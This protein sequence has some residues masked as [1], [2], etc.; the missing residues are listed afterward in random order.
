MRNAKLERTLSHRAAQASMRII[1]SAF[2]AFFRAWPLAWRISMKPAFTSL[3][4][5][6]CRGPSGLYG[7]SALVAEF[8]G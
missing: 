5:L 6:G 8:T 1:E 2:L 7:S 3:K 4:V